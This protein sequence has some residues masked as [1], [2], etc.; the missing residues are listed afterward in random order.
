M[1]KQQGVGCRRVVLG[2]VLVGSLLG[3]GCRPRSETGTDDQ[4]TMSVP[5]NPTEGTPS[6]AITP[7][8]PT[9]PTATGSS[10]IQNTPVP[11]GSPEV[12]GSVGETGT[13]GLP[14]TSGT[15]P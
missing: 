15:Q 14:G 5:G 8:G 4:A 3:A 12:T 1:P 9:G 7:M 2:A 10:G 11:G 13:T 6:P